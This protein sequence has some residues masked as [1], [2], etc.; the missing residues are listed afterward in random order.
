VLT[1]Y[2]KARAK[3][4]KVLVLNTSFNNVKVIIYHVSILNTALIV[5][6]INIYKYILKKNIFLYN[7]GGSIV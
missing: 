6:E 4:E 5:L 7:K 1:N 2:T 3:I